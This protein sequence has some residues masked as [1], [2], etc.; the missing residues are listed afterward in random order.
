MWKGGFG[1]R[2]FDEL[3]VKSEIEM[4]EVVFVKVGGWKLCRNTLYGKT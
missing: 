4:D 3:G 2:G 1:S